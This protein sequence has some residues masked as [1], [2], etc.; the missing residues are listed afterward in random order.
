MG[1]KALVSSINYGWNGSEATADGIGEKI[2]MC[3]GVGATEKIGVTPGDVSK[4]SE[5][6]LTIP[7]NFRATQET[8]D[9]THAKYGAGQYNMVGNCVVG[10]NLLQGNDHVHAS[11]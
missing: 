1:R 6:E 9:T 8:L 7:V 11:G 2:R 5:G 4:I 3:L 10:P